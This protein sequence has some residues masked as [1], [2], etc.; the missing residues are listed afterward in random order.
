MVNIHSR[1]FSTQ[2]I[3]V[4]SASKLSSIITK[5]FRPIST[6][7]QMSN[8]LPAGVSALKMMRYISRLVMF[9]YF[10]G[11]RTLNISQCM[12]FP[13]ACTVRLPMRR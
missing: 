5:R 2:R 9:L 10:L 1:L 11:S 3:L 8:F 13:T 6:S 12:K 7:S 4:W